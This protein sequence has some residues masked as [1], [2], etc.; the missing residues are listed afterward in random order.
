MSVA[1]VSGMPASSP[2][3]GPIERF[4][5]EDHVQIDRH[6]DAATAGPAIDADAYARFRHGL[7][8]H[9]GMEEKILL[10]DARARRGGEPLDVA[11]RLREDHGAIAK[12]LVRS[13]TAST[14]DSLR[15]LLGRHNAVEEGPCG[16]YATCDALAGEDAPAVVA[17]LRVQPAVPMAKYYD[18]P[19]HRRA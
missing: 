11:S 14:I 6:L 13:P 5:T 7:L 15:E 4:M 9:I 17:Q 10:P 19:L 12:L 1:V 16:L 18:G 2:N 3:V 8:R